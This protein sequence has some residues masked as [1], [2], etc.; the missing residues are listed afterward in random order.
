MNIGVPSLPLNDA[1][2]KV[3]VKDAAILPEISLIGSDEYI[4]L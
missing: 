3:I 2:G 1:G 4:R